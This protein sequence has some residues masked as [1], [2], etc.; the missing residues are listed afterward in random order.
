[1]NIASKNHA[2]VAGDRVI[3]S[4]LP[5]LVVDYAWLPPWEGHT[6]SR[7]NRVKVIFSS[8]ACVTLDHAGQG[9]QVAVAPGGAHVMGEESTFDPARRGTQRDD[10]SL[11]RPRL[12]EA[13]S[14]SARPKR[15]RN[16]VHIGASACIFLRRRSG[17][18]RARDAFQKR[19][20]GSRFILPDGFL[21][22]GLE[23]RRSSRRSAIRHPTFSPRR[24]R[25]EKAPA[26]EGQ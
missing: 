25:I 5:G 24:S 21:V 10:R 17:I 7:P 20:H 4:A 23:A 22:A 16:A 12:V 3:R 13:G 1:M 15:L 11:S 18:P 14:C 2:L 8:H 9:R 19:L 6:E 26:A